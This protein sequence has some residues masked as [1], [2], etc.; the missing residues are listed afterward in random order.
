MKQYPSFL[1]YKKYHF[2]NNLFFSLKAQKSFYP[3][4][5][6]FC[7]KAIDSGKLTFK[8]IEACRKSVRRNMRKD[9]RI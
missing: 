9:G 6:L 7:I 4:N 3:L 1:K 2:V 5:G 8:Q